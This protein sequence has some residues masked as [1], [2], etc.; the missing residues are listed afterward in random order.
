MTGIVRATTITELSRQGFR[1]EE[2]ASLT[3]HCDLKMV[4]Y[5]DHAELENNPSR[6]VNMI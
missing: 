3:G 1:A 4:G 5:Y 6:K 2:I